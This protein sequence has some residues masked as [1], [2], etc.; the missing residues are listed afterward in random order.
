LILHVR[1]SSD[2]AVP[3]SR[4][5]RRSFSPGLFRLHVKLAL[6]AGVSQDELRDVVRFCGEMSLAK[7]VAVQRELETALKHA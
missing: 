2:N 1:F 3:E 5:E 7:A 6:E 4:L